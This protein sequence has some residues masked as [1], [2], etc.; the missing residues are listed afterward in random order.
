M[1]NQPCSDDL[2]ADRSAVRND[3]TALESD[4]QTT[5]IDHRRP[6]NYLWWKNYGSGERNYTPA[7]ENDSRQREMTKRQGTSHPKVN[8]HDF[9]I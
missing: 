4:R 5:G 1:T 9:I 3:T 6:N 2:S 7:E 8:V